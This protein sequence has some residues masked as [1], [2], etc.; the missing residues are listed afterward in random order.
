[1]NSKFS[2]TEILNARN[3]WRDLTYADLLMFWR[4]YTIGGGRGSYVGVSKNT[5]FLDYLVLSAAQSSW[6]SAHDC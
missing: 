5:A 1:M 4:H 3:Y 2:K 6:E